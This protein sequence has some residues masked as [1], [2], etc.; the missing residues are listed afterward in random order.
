M[1]DFMAFGTI[2][3]SRNLLVFKAQSQPVSEMLDMLKLRTWCCLSAKVPIF[4]YPFSSWLQ[5]LGDCLSLF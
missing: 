5:N 1:A 2:W 4:S 3:L